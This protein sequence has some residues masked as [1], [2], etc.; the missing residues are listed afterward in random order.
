MARNKADTT[1]REILDVAMRMFL[2]RGYSNTSIKAISDELDISTGNL[3]FHYPTKEHLLAKLAGLLCEFQWKLME[4]A[5]DE[6][7]TS[8]LALCME[9]AAMAVVCEEDEVARDFYLS[10]YKH[11]MSLD[12]I[13]KSDEKRAKHVFAQWCGCWSD[14]QFHQAEIIVSGIEYAT[15]MKTDDFPL[16]HRIEGALNAIMMI[17]NVPENVRQKKIEKVL[18]LDYRQMGRR[19]MKDF[20]EY[21]NTE[22]EQA[23]EAARKNVL[24]GGSIYE[25]KNYKKNYKL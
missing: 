17:Y 21:I 20:E 24:Q 11:N 10:A 3:T 12:L 23:L 22:N 14:A 4:Q 16:E 18:A 13:R 15:L 5:V 25:R 7:E 6:G 2:E 1:K 8:L 19:I 9:L